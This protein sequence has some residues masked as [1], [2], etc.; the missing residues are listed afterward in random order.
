M[1]ELALRHNLLADLLGKRS[2]HYVDIPVHGNIGDL[3]IL[4]GTMA[5]FRGKRLVPKSVAPAFAFG[6]N[7]IRDG[8]AVVFHGGGNFGDLYSASGSQPLREEIVRMFPGNRILV[9]PQTLHFSSQATRAKSA[10]VF[11]AHPDVHLCVRDLNSLQIAGEFSDNV[12]LMPD[13]A[14]SLYPMRPGQ[15]RAGEG[16]LLLARTD[17]EKT[18]LPGALQ[19]R[20]ATQSD[21]PELV[22]GRERQIDRFRRV[23]RMLPRRGFG[24]ASSRLCSAAWVAYSARLIDDAIDLFSE[25]ERIVTDRLHGHILACLMD[26]PNTVLDNSY[27][28]NSAYVEAW[29]SGSALV[30]P[31]KP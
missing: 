28:K 29:T 10:R 1:S 20:F 11:R 27:G 12:Y 5:F 22:G 3:L 24:M 15:S 23:M 13:M 17:R 25:H 9:L 8:D 7:W 26:L 4:H 19:E 14:H 18:V 30:S 2:F 16:T 31:R 21:W 6:R